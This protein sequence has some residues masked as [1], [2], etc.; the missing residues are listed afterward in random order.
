VSGRT[1]FTCAFKP[2]SV[3]MHTSEDFD[4]YFSSCVLPIR[5]RR[6]GTDGRPGRVHSALINV[7]AVPGFKRISIQLDLPGQILQDD[8]FLRHTPGIK[9]CYIL[10]SSAISV[11]VS[12]DHSWDRS[13]LPENRKGPG[14]GKSRVRNRR[15]QRHYIHSATTSPVR[16]MQY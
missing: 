11:D 15:L 16:W 7:G 8:D 1:D 13:I 9:E 3:R 5:K 4:C 14:R 6:S 10:P 2:F 12:E